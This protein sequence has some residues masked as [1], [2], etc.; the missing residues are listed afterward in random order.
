MDDDHTFPEGHMA[1][2]IEAVRRDPSALWTTGERSFVD[3]EYFAFAPM[4]NQLHPSGVG[5]AVSDPDNNWAVADGATIYPRKVFDDNFRFV[6]V[7]G[8]GSTYLE[9]GALLYSRGWRSRCI[10]TAFIEHHASKLTLDRHAPLN[11]LFASVCYNLHFRRD[12]LRFVRFAA[13]YV[14]HFRALPVMVRI[15]NARWKM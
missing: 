9:F 5:C 11:H 3:G 2:C 13:P 12:L 10:P 6:E 1:T 7:F 14:R 15:S 8:F 4:A